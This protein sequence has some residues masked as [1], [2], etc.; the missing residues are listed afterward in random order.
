M[1]RH[2]DPAASDRGFTLAETLVS[3]VL[4]GLVSGM[5]TSAAV[6]GLHNQAQVQDRKDAL[7]QARTALQRIDRDI[8]SADYPV[9]FVN[10]T[11]LVLAEKQGT[12]TRRMT[13]SV[14]GP[15]LNVDERDYSSSGSAS[16]VPTRTLLDDLVT[17]GDPVFSFASYSGYQA[18]SGT[19]V[20]TS[21]CALTDGTIDTGCV[22]TIT[23]TVTVQP[24]GLDQPV[25][26]TDNGTELRNAP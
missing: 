19:N 9:W 7:A 2:V 12:V 18:R 24:Q 17:T 16:D 22:G 20:N 25:S 11:T 14:A 5:V 1:R 15:D 3:I 10:S 8:R 21:T 6:S 26:L 13:Y 23:V 4:F